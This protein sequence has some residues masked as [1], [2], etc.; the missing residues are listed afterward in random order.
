MM[1]ITHGRRFRVGVGEHMYSPSSL[2][3]TLME[4]ERVSR[5]SDDGSADGGTC[6]NERGSDEESVRDMESGQ[7][8]V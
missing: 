4:R 3:V 5:M 8:G 2:S 1:P 6:T 7:S